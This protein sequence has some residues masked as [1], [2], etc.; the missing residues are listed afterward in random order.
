M[1]IVIMMICDKDGYDY[2]DIDGH[3]DSDDYFSILTLFHETHI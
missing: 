2:D 3:D 1:L